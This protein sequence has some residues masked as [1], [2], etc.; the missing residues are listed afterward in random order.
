MGKEKW[1]KGVAAR[2]G[3]RAL[4]PGLL[5]KLTNTFQKQT[6]HRHCVRTEKGR[7]VPP[8][9]VTQATGGQVLQHDPALNH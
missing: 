8:A 6:G 1:E 5:T 3:P 2:A 4:R 7:E 9:R